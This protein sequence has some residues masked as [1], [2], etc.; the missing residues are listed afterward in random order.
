MFKNSGFW[1]KKTNL[2][3]LVFFF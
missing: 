2:I 3:F 1:V